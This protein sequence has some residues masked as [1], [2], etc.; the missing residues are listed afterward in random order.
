VWSV[1][2][3]V[4]EQTRSMTRRRPCRWLW[5]HSLVD[6]LTIPVQG[7]P[8]ASVRETFEL[9]QVLV[10]GRHRARSGWVAHGGPPSC[11]PMEMSPSPPGY[12]AG[13][14]GAPLGAHPGSSVG[15]RFVAPGTGRGGRP[16]LVCGDRPSWLGDVVV[17]TERW[18]L[19]APVAIRGPEG[20]HATSARPRQVIWNRISGRVRSARIPQC[21]ARPPNLW[22]SLETDR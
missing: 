21:G 17:R 8:E 16:G 6:W 15:Y 20:Q 12:D 11:F 10:P 14:P 2:A 19:V 9:G 22:E 3:S 4:D 13:R 18:A 5:A 1:S 7:D